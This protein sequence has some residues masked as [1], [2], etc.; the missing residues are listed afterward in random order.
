MFNLNFLETHDGVVINELF[1]AVAQ[2][3]TLFYSVN[4]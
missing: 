1:T 3:S 4:T 2:E